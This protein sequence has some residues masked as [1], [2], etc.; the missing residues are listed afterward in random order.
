MEK[1]KYLFLE[2][3]Y[4]DLKENYKK[5]LDNKE[6]SWD[7]VVLT[8]SN[9]TQAKTY[10]AQLVQRKKEKLLSENTDYLVIPDVGG[11]RIGSGGATLNVLLE[12]SKK[13]DIL[14]KKI[15]I[16]HSGGDSKRVP[17]YSSM[18]KLF[19]P[20]PR[21]FNPHKASTLFDEAMILTAALP[22]RMD[23]GVFIMCGDSLVLF[24]PLQVDLQY[25]QAAVIS[26]KMPTEKGTKHGV[27]VSNKDNI[28]TS[29]LHKQPLEV[30]EEK[31]ASN[32]HIDFDTGM[33]YF[34]S[35]VVNK[36]LNLVKTKKDYDLFISEES[37]LN[38]YG[39]FLYPMALDSKYQDY[40][41]ESCENKFNKPLEI[42]RNKIWDALNEINLKIVKLSP[43]LFL[44]F[45]TTQELLNTMTDNIDNYYYLGWNKN[46]V[47]YTEDEKNITTIN[48]FVE[49]S[50]VGKNVYVENSIIKD[51]TIGNNVII[52]GAK[53]IGVNI[54]DNVAISTIILKN[55]K[56]VTR[57][58]D[59]SLN[60]KDIISDDSKLF[61]VNESLVLNQHKGK[62][63]W[64][65]KI[66]TISKDEKSSV[67]D[68]LHLY[69]VATSTAT[70]KE[71]VEYINSEKT[72]LFDS[73][74]EAD[75]EKMIL[76]FSKLEEEIIIKKITSEI[77]QHKNLNNLASFINSLNNKK[78]ILSKL[79][80]VKELD[81]MRFN[82]L[83]YILTNKNE[84]LKESFDSI[85]N[86]LTDKTEEESLN[87]TK[88]KVEIKSPV[89]VNFG[90]G[91]SDTPPYCIENGGT[92]L[93]VAIKVN[94]TYPI[95]A[96]I[97]KI[98]E[99]KLIFK[100]IDFN[101]ITEIKTIEEIR[102]CSNP[103]DPYALLKCA[104]VI[105]GLVKKSDKQLKDV[106][107]RIGSGFMI[108]TNTETIP[109]G[110]GLGTSSILSGTVLKA[111]FDFMG[112]KKSDNE[113]SYE[114]LRLEQL[115]STG[116]GWQDQVGGLVNGIKL[117]TTKPGKE[118]TLNIKQLKVSKETINN[119]N[120]RLLLI[121]TSQRRLARNLLRD[122]MGKYI[123]GNEETVTILSQIQD[124]A[125]KMAQSLEKGN[126][127]QFANQLNEHWKL[128][129]RL[130]IGCT[131]TCIEFIFESIKDLISGRFICGAGG[132]G[133]LTVLL[134]NGVTKKDIDERINNVFQDSGVE[135]WTLTVEE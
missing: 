75:T 92:V 3:S 120:D 55:N 12:L 96:S 124:L 126:L 83:M 69:K 95:Q 103:N 93:N 116:G 81:K 60:P 87:F 94:G 80:K 123:S 98:P 133:F 38:I 23:K 117:I 102:N 91:W 78:K 36:L 128:S 8:A 20:I 32:G 90:G 88:Q 68:A 1:I 67:N 16:I 43:A 127:D 22:V 111:I 42:C 52:S 66:F 73:F 134:R 29:F 65:A 35:E 112:I 76:S 17:Q 49:N 101:D 31:A 14:S 41:R 40:L 77:N 37:C 119:L 85:K 118:Q 59:I 70:E 115:M 131:N 15:L 10:E 5:V 45:G 11:K 13:Y 82:Y 74:N 97:E 19:A 62:T 34:S 79:S 125:Q 21:E 6:K 71:Q 110:S 84:Y 105:S 51:S 89:R 24:N 47:S 129:K 53:L 63:F 9:M 28:V 4:S 122:V 18:G 86:T 132:G 106:F 104:V 108:T 56:Y 57:I 50:S 135:T 7:I 48:S 114:V 72:S 44:H 58:Y 39:D 33:I 30:L 61:N 121:N 27:F 109:R 107:T 100:C 26:M 2:N 113:I 99:E 25:K 130:D 46:I 64:E 54:P